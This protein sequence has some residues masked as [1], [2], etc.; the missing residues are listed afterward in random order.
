MDDAAAEPEILLP[1]PFDAVCFFPFH[2]WTRLAVLR[3]KSDIAGGLGFSVRPMRLTSHLE[4]L[5]QVSCS[6]VD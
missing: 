4:N 3:A 5:V 2:R 1:Q 6:I